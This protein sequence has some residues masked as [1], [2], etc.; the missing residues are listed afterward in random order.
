MT[1]SIYER[2]NKLNAAYASCIDEDK[3]ESWPAFFT[4]HCLYKIT[5][6]E[7]YE[8]NLPAG[9]IYA[10]SKGML[11]DR[12]SALREANVYERQ[13]YRHIIGT[14]LITS[15][16]P[17]ATRAETPFLVTR[18]MRGGKMDL[19]ATGKYVDQIV[20]HNEEQ[21]LEKRIVVCDS[22]SFDT[23]LAIPL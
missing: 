13:R 17:E 7:N 14:P 12:V 5:T 1:T 6:A 11:A 22:I 18:I 8:S 15:N 16:T 4:D 19:F 9:I 10:D 20:A 3:L 2:L 21:K 23:L